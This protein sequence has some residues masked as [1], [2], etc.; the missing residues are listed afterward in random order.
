MSSPPLDAGD[1]IRSLSNAVFASLDPGCSVLRLHD[2][3]TDELCDYQLIKVSRLSGPSQTARWSTYNRSNGLA[4][5]AQET[6]H[7][8]ASLRSPAVYAAQHSSG[9]FY[10]L[11]RL[12]PISVR[13][14]GD[15]TP[16]LFNDSCCSDASSSLLEPTPVRQ[17]F[18]CP[19][20]PNLGNS[21]G[22]C[23]RATDFSGVAT[24]VGLGFSS[25]LKDDGSPFDGLGSLPRRT[26]TPQG[27]HTTSPT[28]DRAVWTW[29]QHQPTTCD[30][31]AFL[32]AVLETGN[33]IARP[34]DTI[35]SIPD[36]DASSHIPIKPPARTPTSGDSV[37]IPRRKPAPRSVGPSPSPRP[38]TSLSIRSHSTLPVRPEQ[39]D[40]FLSRPIRV[41]GSLTRGFFRRASSTARSGGRRKSDQGMGKSSFAGDVGRSRRWSDWVSGGEEITKKPVWRP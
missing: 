20:T 23:S 31:G 9:V 3:L 16:S 7:R 12:P 26:S 11:A 35:P 8:S 41:P 28:D 37:C 27:G 36:E 38:S 10:P 19:A 15:G 6:L 21:S 2:P 24:R 22:D 32:D 1:D 17:L 14:R 5:T 39:D 33:P 30:L 18:P 34:D 40:V 29:A 13:S 4:T 25:L